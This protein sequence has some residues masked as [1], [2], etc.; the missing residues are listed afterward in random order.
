LTRSG[1]SVTASL[2]LPVRLAR[3]HLRADAGRVEVDDLAERVLR[4]PGDAEDGLVAIQAHPVV[5]AVVPQ[6][7]GID[8]FGHGR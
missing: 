8:P 2:T 4:V 7:V 1:F 3:R 5:L 6:I